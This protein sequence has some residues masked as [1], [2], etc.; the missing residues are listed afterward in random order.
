M[1]DSKYDIRE[2][3]VK[4]KNFFSIG[5][6]LNE[7]SGDFLYALSN[8]SA[9]VIIRNRLKSIM[10][11]VEKSASNPSESDRLSYFS[12]AHLKQDLIECSVNSYM[13]V[14]NGCTVKFD[15]KFWIDM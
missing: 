11:I 10:S 7:K 15:S 3:L 1:L 4:C 6:V 2:I 8:M 5:F 13:Q 9:Q 12:E 14:K